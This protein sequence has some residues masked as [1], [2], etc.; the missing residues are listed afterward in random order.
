MKSLLEFLVRAIV[1]QP[2]KVKIETATEANQRKFL[3]KLAQEDIPLVI[4]H[5]GKIIKAI[6]ILLAAKSQG[7]SFSLEVSQI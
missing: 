5:Q 6:R 1:T 4:G 7:K 3:I 2:D